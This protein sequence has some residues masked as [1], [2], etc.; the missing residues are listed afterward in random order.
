M[1]R[2]D[3]EPVRMQRNYSVDI[4]RF[5]CAYLVI[6]LHI[7]TPYSA[8]TEPIARCAVPL[9]FMMSGF[10]G[11]AKIYR[12]LKIIVLSTLVYLFVNILPPI[13]EIKEGLPWWKTQIAIVFFNENPSAFHLWYLSA[14]LYVLLLIPLIKKYN[15]WQLAY[16]IVPLLLA[17]GIVLGKYSNLLFHRDFYAFL[18][19]NFLCVG[20]PFY[21]IGHLIAE[22]KERLLC[23]KKMIYAMSVLPLTVLAVAE[24]L[25][26]DKVF[27]DVYICTVFLSI[28]IFLLT[29]SCRV[30]HE[31]LISRIGRRDA[32]HIYITHLFWIKVMTLLMANASGFWLELYRIT[33]PLVILTISFLAI[34][35]VRLV[36][37][38]K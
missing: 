23:H 19:R 36:I 7:H 10:F 30:E 16:M 6:T 14:Y 33:G 1:G 26:V 28:C 37:K 24:G 34:R 31:G 8:Y 15:M 29:L 9:F 21:L 12:L 2:T 4:L 32:L 35:L 18:S 38:E 22:N 27:G 25:W 5:L 3:R 17:V 11:K 13:G 20:L